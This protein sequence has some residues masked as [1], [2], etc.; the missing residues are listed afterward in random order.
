MGGKQVLNN[1]ASTGTSSGTGWSYD[2]AGTLTLTGGTITGLTTTGNLVDDQYICPGIYVRGAQD[3]TS[4]LTINIPAG[5]TATIKPESYSQGAKAI[6]LHQVQLII[7]GGGT[8]ELV[9]DIPVDATQSYDWSGIKATHGVTINDGTTVN[10]NVKCT[11]AASIAARGLQAG[12]LTMNSGTLNVK[13]LTSNNNTGSIGGVSVQAATGADGILRFN[14]GEINVTTGKT[15][16]TDFRYGIY[17]SGGLIMTG[18]LLKAQ[19][20]TDG[21]NAVS[22]GSGSTADLT[23][24]NG[25]YKWR[26]GTISANGTNVTYT[27]YTYCMDATTNAYAHNNANEYVEIA[28]V[29]LAAVPDYP[30]QGLKDLVAGADYTVTVDGVATQYTAD[31]NGCITPGGATWRSW[32]GKKVTLQKVG[33]PATAEVTLLT[34][35]NVTID[36]DAKTVTFNETGDYYI[37]FIEMPGWSGN[38]VTVNAAGTSWEVRVGFAINI[39]NNPQYPKMPA[40]IDASTGYRR[41]TIA[42]DCT[43][44][45]ARTARISP[46]IL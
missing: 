45:Q 38:P 46:S 34:L 36:L 13:V 16:S 41:T 6:W 23:Q 1:S 17:T 21:G 31:E 10:I 44:A 39:E 14:G 2:G 35:P 24:Y 19:T 33:E 29:P 42:L 15:S 32:L 37:E 3:N 27:P 30:N 7:T 18:G 11:T 25:N 9:V 28:A 5:K 22:I 43:T 40:A 4:T 8:L 12:Q 26:T 20:Y